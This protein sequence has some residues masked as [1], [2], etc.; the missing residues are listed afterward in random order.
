MSLYFDYFFS[1][2][3]Q[4]VTLVTTLAVWAALTSLG[5]LVGGRGRLR[6]GDTLYGWAAVC[7]VFTALG[8]IFVAPFEA[9]AW[10]F[11]IAAPIAGV[12][13]YRREGRLF[14]PGIFKVLLLA[15]PLLLLTSAKGVSEWDEFSHWV[16]HGP[17]PGGNPRLSLGRDIFNRRFVSRLSLSLAPAQLSRQPWGRRLRRERRRRS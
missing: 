15:A 6:E 16:P 8:V 5:G 1:D 9:L 7:L 3:G 12:I 13:L 14:S 4:I 11:F 17:L 10:L 2:G